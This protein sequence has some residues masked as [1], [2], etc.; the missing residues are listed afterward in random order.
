[1][2]IDLH[3]HST[4]S[5]GTMSPTELVDLAQKKGLR[6]IA[7]TDHDTFA[8]YA[9][10]SR[11]GSAVGLEVLSGI[12]LSVRLQDSHL[13]LLGYLFDCEDQVFLGRIEKLQQARDLRNEEIIAKLNALGITITSAELAHVSGS[14]QTGRPHIAQLLLHKKIVRSMDEA[15][16]TYLGQSGSVYVSRFSYEVKEA[17]D[18]VHQAGGVAVLAHPYHLLKD[19]LENGAL[20]GQL[21]DI[22]LDG[23][24]AYYPTHIRKFRKQLIKLA[25]KYGLF[26]TGGSDY[27]GTIRQGTS[28][29][30]GK[31][32]SVPEHLVGI[33]RRAKDKITVKY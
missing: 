1:M 19:D 25:E 7:L 31:G 23:V 13:H 30:G 33:M 4:M 5:D 32:V 12:E 17:I 18:F 15:F 24:E 21:K 28:L 9:E 27:H 29:A 10:A 2:T 8:G 20:L 22:G 3:V 14:G 26:I 11:R 6:A 16:D